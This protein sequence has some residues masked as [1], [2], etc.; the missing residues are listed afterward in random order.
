MSRP[1]LG[2]RPLRDFLDASRQDCSIALARYLFTVGEVAGRVLANVRRATGRGVTF[3]FCYAEGEARR[4]LASLPAFEADLARALVDAGGTSWASSK[5]GTGLN[6][7]VEHPV[8]T[9]VLTIKPPGS[10]HLLPPSLP[11][12]PP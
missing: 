4:R 2:A 12:K 8:G 3:S 9:V 7:M 11:P 10:P 1:R 6:A 5:I